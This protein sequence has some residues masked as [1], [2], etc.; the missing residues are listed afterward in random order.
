VV[1][2]HAYYLD[3]L[4]ITA[5]RFGDFVAKTGHRTSAERGEVRTTWNERG[6]PTSDSAATW[7]DDGSH[8]PLLEVAR[9]VVYVSWVDAE[10]YARWAHARLPTEAE[11]ERA[12]K[13]GHDAYQFPWGETDDEGRRAGITRQHDLSRALPTGRFPSNPFG[14]FDLSGNVYEW[15]NDW[16]DASYYSSGDWRDPQGPPSGKYRVVRGGSWVWTYE[17]AVPL[18]VWSRGRFAPDGSSNDIGFRCAREVYETSVY[19]H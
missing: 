14:I 10:A 6:E 7:R 16:Y 13:G 19:G 8:R 15:C 1:I 4:E 11:W 9:P 3:V 18:T 17:G 2:S 5:A 12:A